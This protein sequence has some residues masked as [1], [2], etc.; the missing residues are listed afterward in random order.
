MAAPVGQAGVGG[1]GLDEHLLDGHQQRREH[2]V[3]RVQGVAAGA[4]AVQ[5]GERLERVAAG[6]G[7]VA[8][9]H[10]LDLATG[11]VGDLDLP[12]DL[13]LAGRVVGHGVE[14]VADDCLQLFVHGIAL[15]V[16]GRGVT[17][18]RRGCRPPCV[19]TGRGRRGR[20][21][22]PTGWTPRV[23]RRGTGS[24]P[25]GGIPGGGGGAAGPPGDGSNRAPRRRRPG[26]GASDPGPDAWRGARGR[27]RTRVSPRAI[28]VPPS[29]PRGGA[30]RPKTW[31][32]A[33]TTRRTGRA[34]FRRARTW[35]ASAAAMAASRCLRRSPRASCA[36]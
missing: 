5:L 36:W 12:G 32:L 9:R 21:G 19:W 26:V 11:G 3:G 18:V 7:G 22:R 14:P 6:G 29:G 23:G 25:G 10:D 13:P 33:C 20:S 27:S 28:L 24:W 16:R 8:G 2:L 31:S 30:C 4:G 17:P 35:T 34:R 15:R 1:E